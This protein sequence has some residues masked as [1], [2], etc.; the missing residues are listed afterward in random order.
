MQLARR[1]A[2]TGLNSFH[3]ACLGTRT[4]ALIRHR[5]PS[6]AGRFQAPCWAP[7]AVSCRQLPSASLGTA[8][9]QL[10]AA[11][12]R[13]LRLGRLLRL[14]LRRLIWRTH[15]F[16]EDDRGAVRSEGGRGSRGACDGC[17][18]WRTPLADDLARSCQ[19]ASAEQTTSDRQKVLLKVLAGERYSGYHL[20]ILACE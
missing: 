11:S 5:R 6:A 20:A 7:Q 4:S 18:L 15:Y 3:C 14:M 8:G 2:K 10:P 17:G 13:L 12:K 16:E 9:G 1:G 19:I